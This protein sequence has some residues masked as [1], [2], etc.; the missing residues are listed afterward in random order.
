MS[1]SAKRAGCESGQ[2]AIESAIVLPLTLFLVLGTL[3]LFLL[4][5]SR[6]SAQ[7]AAYQATRVGSLSHGA[8]K[9]MLH[10]ALLTLLPNIHSFLGDQSLSGSPAQRLGA[11]F[12]RIKENNYGGYQWG[13]WA[14]A[15]AAD[16]AIVWVFREGRAPVAKDVTGFD[17]PLSGGEPFRLEVRMV[18][19]APLRI[20]FADWVYARIAAARMGILPYTN[21][22]PLVPT[23]KTTDWSGGTFTLESKLAQ[24]LRKRLIAGHYV[25]PIT[26]SSTMRMMT[27]PR[28]SEFV[29]QDCQSPGFN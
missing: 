9:P 4:Q 1:R 24:E 21:Y 3:Q 13:G 26:T 18:Y 14:S 27:P 5:Q 29:R 7:Y 23:K 6:I 17:Q 15:G 19:W 8:C 11:A 2:A 22:D 12:T 10:A 16:E 20:P 28:L 25:F